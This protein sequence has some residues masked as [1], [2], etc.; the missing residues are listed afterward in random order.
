MINLRLFLAVIG[1]LAISTIIFLF[2]D[3]SI[4]EDYSSFVSHASLPL[5]NFFNLNPLRLLISEPLYFVALKLPPFF[6]ADYPA[7]LSLHFFSIFILFSLVLYRL[8]LPGI[9]VLVSP[10]F[11]SVYTL[12]LQ[13]CLGLSCFI[14]SIRSPYVK[15]ARS[16]IFAVSFTALPFILSILVHRS[17]FVFLPLFLLASLTQTL[18]LISLRS[19]RLLLPMLSF[20]PILWIFS[21]LNFQFSF[22]FGILGLL[23][24]LCIILLLV[25]PR[26]FGLPIY[27]SQPNAILL[28]LFYT[29]IISMLSLPTAGRVIVSIFFSMLTLSLPYKRYLYIYI[30]FAFIS[31]FSTLSLFSDPSRFLSIA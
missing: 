14:A 4:F 5:D 3:F 18:T 22:S 17:F 20:I 29:G 28:M 2:L 7:I 31:L 24:L 11:F 23:L 1:A 27:I 16:D 6:I 9:L 13:Y 30:V 8:G 21:S 12:N 19:W 10:Y 25:R 26:S 15:A